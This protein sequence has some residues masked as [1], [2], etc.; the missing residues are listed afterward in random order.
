MRCNDSVNK[1]RR[2]FIHEYARREDVPDKTMFI[3]TTDG[4]ENASRRYDCETV[5]R[6]IR[7]E[8]KKYG[9]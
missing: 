1:R 2:V 5:R 4:Y 8:K 7:H 3:I 9:M 6:M